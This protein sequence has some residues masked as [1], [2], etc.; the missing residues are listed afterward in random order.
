MPAE[1]KVSKFE[2]SP[3]RPNSL[4]S[5]NGAVTSPVIHDQ[6]STDGKNVTVPIEKHTETD[7]NL[8]KGSM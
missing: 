7:K 8:A 2:V 1:R 4:T 3:V 6:H 5:E